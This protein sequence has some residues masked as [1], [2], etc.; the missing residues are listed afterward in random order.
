MSR[1]VLLLWAVVLIELILPVPAFLSIGA[2][3]VLVARP[4][5][6]PKLVN[7]LY[8]GDESGT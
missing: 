1:T 2:I 7:E 6:L 4:P 8:R 5:W 3:W